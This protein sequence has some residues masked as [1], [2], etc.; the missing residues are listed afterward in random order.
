MGMSIM[1]LVMV[2]GLAVGTALAPA[3]GW[4]AD[5]P[6]DPYKQKLQIKDI[7][8][9][10]GPVAE[11]RARV[12]VHYTGWLEGGD[13]HGEQFDTSRDTNSPFLF[14]L[15]KG[16]VI[17]GW[18]EGVDGMR[19]G[20]IRELII[21]PQK[22]YGVR[23]FGDRIPPHSTLKFEVELVKVYPPPVVH[24]IDAETL[25]SMMAEGVAAADIRPDSERAKTG[26]IE[27]TVSVPAYRDNMKMRSSF[28]GAILKQ[29][30]LPEKIIIVGNTGKLTKNLGGFMIERFGYRHV[31]HL[32]GGIE[33]WIADG[34]PVV[35][36]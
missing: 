26:M 21:P 32:A 3:T 4:S 13:R 14:T 9:G 29:A 36:E 23:G 24:D 27:G 35:T 34:N 1:K 6:V 25:K 18:D 15:N 7:K 30:K 16:Q 2:V 12:R 17:R 10:T 8:I 5:A 11:G 19:E 22:A 20:G 33:K 31:Y 28:V